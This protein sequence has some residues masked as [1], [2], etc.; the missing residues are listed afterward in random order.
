MGTAAAL[1]VAIASLYFLFAGS[2]R[3]G[4]KS[5]EKADAQAESRRAQ[6]RQLNPESAV[7]QTR[8][9]GTRPAGS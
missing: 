6:D 7:D 4:V 8:R 9:E 1:A 2:K 5:S 3:Q